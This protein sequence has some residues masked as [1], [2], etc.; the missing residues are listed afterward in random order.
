MRGDDLVS[1]SVGP[2]GEAVALWAESADAGGLLTSDVHLGPLTRPVGV[3]AVLHTPDP[4]HTVEIPDYRFRFPTVQ[5]MPGGAFLLVG[6]RVP[7]RGDDVPSNA[8]VY[9]A[10]GQ[11]I[12]EGLLGDGIKHVQTTASGQVWVG[13]S[14]EG[15]YGN[16]GWGNGPGTEPIGAPGLIRYTPEL[17]SDWE[18]SNTRHGLPPVDDCY[19]LNVISETAWCCYDSGFPLVKIRDETV[20]AWRNE[21]QR[22]IGIA[23]HQGHVGL[24]DGQR[25]T[26]AHRASDQ[27]AIEHKYD[28]ALPNGDPPP[29]N[30]KTISRASAIHIFAG[31]SW[32]RTDLAEHL[33]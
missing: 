24:Y 31:R 12:A 14:D 22:V 7:R 3:R 20:R 15:V 25:L 30:S 16:L 27:L 17:T 23:V 11:P 9:D 26:I 8:I 32:Y 19:A 5:S 28:V 6:K 10:I 13:Y 2:S 33:T 1:V 18:F 4:C 21:V 29:P